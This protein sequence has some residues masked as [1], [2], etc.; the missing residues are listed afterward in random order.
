MCSIVLRS[1]FLNLIL[2][3][4]DIVTGAHVCK[5]DG[6]FADEDDCTKYYHCANG[7]ALPS[8]CPAGLFWN[9]GKHANTCIEVTCYLYN[10]PHAIRRSQNL[11]KI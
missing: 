4:S 1:L 9:Q 3:M 2:L 7:R 5:S 11:S 8:F 6:H 10:I